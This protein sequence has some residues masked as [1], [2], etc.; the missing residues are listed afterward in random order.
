MIPLLMSGITVF[1]K[2]SEPKLQMVFDS[3]CAFWNVQSI[4]M[5]H[6]EDMVEKITRLRSLACVLCNMGPEEIKRNM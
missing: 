4:L 2:E 3:S 6:V 5:K 1:L